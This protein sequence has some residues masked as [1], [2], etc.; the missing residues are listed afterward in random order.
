MNA[1]YTSETEIQF[2]GPKYYTT[3][4]IVSCAFKMGFGFTS[5]PEDLNSDDCDT[6]EAFVA[7]AMRKLEC[8]LECEREL[9]LL[10]LGFWNFADQILGMNKNTLQ[11]TAITK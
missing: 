10:Y 9:R 4:I 3:L 5:W 2:N 7:L 6:N 8:E 11:S 1:M